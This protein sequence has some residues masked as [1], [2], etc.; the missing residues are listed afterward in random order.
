MPDRRGRSSAD[1]GR[2]GRLQ[3]TVPAVAQAEGSRSVKTAPPDAS[4]ENS[5]RP[6]L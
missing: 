5:M 6:P 2:G 1:G 4:E 3:G